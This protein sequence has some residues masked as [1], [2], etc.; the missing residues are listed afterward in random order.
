M[1]PS[2]DQA[3]ECDLLVIGAGMGGLTAA[4]LA[5]DA[6]RSVIVVERA[7]TVG[8]SAVLSS[9]YLWSL[10]TIDDFAA[11]APGGR[12]DL[13]QV[14]IDE[15]EAVV[16]WIASTGA[17]VGDRIP[18]LH[19][20]GNQI[21]VQ[22]YSRRCVTLVQAAGGQVVIDAS[23]HELIV[24]DGAV[25]GAVVDDPSARVT[26]RADHVLIAT[27]GFAKNPDLLAELVHP[28][29]ATMRARCAPF[30]L[31]DGL[32]LVRR[33]GAAA[34]EPAG[35]YG[36]LVGAGVDLSDPERWDN[37]TLLHSRQAVLLDRFG[38][39]ITDET[40][41]DNVNAEAALLAGRRGLLV[42]DEAVHQ[43]V[44]LVSWPPGYAA[45][46]KFDVAL[47]AG[48]SGARC[49]DLDQLC[50]FAESHG[51]E[52]KQ[53]VTTLVDFD[54]QVAAGRHGERYGVSRAPFYALLVEPA[55]TFPYA[56]IACDAHARVLDHSGVPIKGLLAAG[57]DIGSVFGGGYAG[58]LA[59]ASTFARRAMKTAGIIGG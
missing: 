58:G 19:G 52:G 27:G 54:A 40:L 10:P 31:G 41:G 56:G 17:H 4:A 18:V 46:D 30:C 47:R 35:F 51:F 14:L 32:R 6:G 44:L 42:W 49:D 20:R 38:L 11:V 8:G 45:I 9:G 36:H 29:A 1:G 25:I 7:H 43:E 23:V 26:V 3:L 48:G 24:E 12:R 53:A 59:L 21:D 55:I 39:R 57:V 16:Q 37:F 5:A 28:A 2:D 50:A 15:F 33:V 22:T 13:Q 34:T